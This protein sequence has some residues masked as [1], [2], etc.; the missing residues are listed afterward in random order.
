LQA[1]S[2]KI[3]IVRKSKVI[4]HE[5]DVWLDEN[6]LAYR[7]WLEAVYLFQLKPK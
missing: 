1:S 5:W 6:G 3:P 4:K 2:R 7:T